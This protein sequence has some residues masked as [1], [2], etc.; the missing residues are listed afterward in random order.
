MKYYKA[1]ILGMFIAAARFLYKEDKDICVTHRMIESSKLPA[2]FD[3]YKIVHISDFHNAYFG[4]GSRKLLDVIKDQDGDVILM[5][6]DII[7]RRTPN[8]KRALRFIE[9][10]TNILPTYYVTGN[11]EAHYRK[12][13]LLKKRIEQSEMYNIGNKAISLTKNNETIDLVGINDPWFFGHEDDPY[14]FQYFKAQLMQ[15]LMPLRD[16]GKF[17]LLMAHRPELFNIYKTMPVDL[18]LSGHAHGGQIRLPY[19][20]GLYAPHQGILPKY[21]EGV[22][23]AHGT[24]LSI[25]RG[26]GNSRFPFRVFNHPEVVVI[27]LKKT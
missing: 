6:G 19:V 12:W 11:H 9:G 25:S 5:T 18:V 7:D 8:L 1:I 23:E 10:M 16:N 17:T 4:R 13:P 26:L 20:K 14:V 21:S 22:H 27:T 24:V 3:G 2:S 15:E